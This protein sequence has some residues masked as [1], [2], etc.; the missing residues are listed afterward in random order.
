MTRTVAVFSL[1][2]APGVTSV[3]MAL[4]AVWPGESPGLLVEADP[5]GGAVAVWRRVPTEPGLTSLAAATRGGGGADPDQHTQALPGGL[6]VCPAPVTGDPAEG[7]VRLLG[8]QPLELGAV[9]APVVVLDL[10]RLTASSPARALV[11][12]ADHTVLVVSERLTDLRRAREH[13][14]APSFPT[15]DLRIVVSGGRGGVGQIVGALGTAV[16]GRIP[17]DLRS[18]EFLRGERDLARPQRR[19]LF[20]AAGRLAR[21]LAESVPVPASEPERH[22]VHAPLPPGVRA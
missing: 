15:R 14:L 19:P 11:P 17:D 6:L 4:A 18:A 1:G 16:W 12:A 5:A 20:R 7:A 13:L 22:A 10:G 21:A 9:S 2:G 3:G 8:R